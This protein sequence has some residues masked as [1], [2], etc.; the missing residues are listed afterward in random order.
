M[1]PS[2]PARRPSA[3]AS[4]TPGGVGVVPPPEAHCVGRRDQD[5]AAPPVVEVLEGRGVL[6]DAPVLAGQHP[7][8]ISSHPG[9]GRGGDPRPGGRDGLH[10]PAGHCGDRRGRA[11]CPRGRP[12]GRRVAHRACGRLRRCPAGGWARR[13]TACGR[14][15]LRLSAAR[16]RGPGVGRVWH[17][18]GLADALARRA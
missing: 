10:V 2:P 18:F 5:D 3:P 11:S 16:C 14:N 15:G 8:M 7:H 9:P 6:V 12:G 13:G 4:P 17:L 1:S